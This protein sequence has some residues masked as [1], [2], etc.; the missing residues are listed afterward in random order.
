MT[1][2]WK[3]KCTCHL[4]PNGEPAWVGHDCSL[5]TC[6][7]G[8]A[9]AAKP[10]AVNN[11]HPLTECSNKGM[12][13]RETGECKCFDDYDGMACERT[14]CPNDCSGKGV[15][16]SQKS[17]AISALTVYESPWDAEKHVGC[18]CDIGYR[19][20]DC[21]QKECPSGSDIMGGDG[22]IEGRDCSGRGLCNYGAGLC[23]CFT[24]YFGDRW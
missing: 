16:L 14:S 2:L 22:N 12:C 7:Y 10:V 6:P 19:G 4:G 17:L 18:K 3:D 11:G 1:L 15:C 21:S 20:P 23:H 5:R 9:W 8:T 13:N 24:G